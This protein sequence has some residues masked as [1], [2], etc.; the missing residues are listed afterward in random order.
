MLQVIYYMF[1]SIT[2]FYGLYYAITG[3]WGFFKPKT[4]RIKP[5]LPK[6]KFAVIIPARNEAD[7]VGHLVSSL[8]ESNYPKKLFDVYV[9]VNNTTDNSKEVAKKA[10]AKVIDVKIKVK[11]KGE[12]LRYVFDKLKNDK[13]IDAYV[14]FDADNIVHPDFLSRMNDCLCSGYNVAE[15]FRDSK[16]ITDNWISGS[17]SLYYYMQNFFFNKSRMTLG[18]SGSINGTGFMIRKDKIDKEGFE[19]KTMT[20]DIE[21]TAQCALKNEPIA[22]VEGAITYDEQP[23]NFKA[24]WK[25]R[26][27]WSVGC[28]QCMKLY[29]FNLL[30]H[31][32]KTGNSSAFD[33][34]MNFIAPVVQVICLIEF[35]ALIL[36]RIFNVQLYDVFSTLFSSG[37][38]FLA[39]SYISGV[40][41]SIFVIKYNKRKSKN[42]ISAI[43]LFA[44]FILTWIPINV[45]C[46]FK[47]DLKWEE[48]KHKRGMA[49]SDIGIQK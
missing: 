2:L 5:Y 28:L 44:L 22:F 42:V 41:V 8:M 25:Q 36:F 4:F 1:F 10:G 6:H 35:V 31:F 40:I 46:L 33:M 38:V 48:I 18:T 19:T 12:V 11:S 29:S 16:N 43:V 27:R 15:G 23:V 14:I 9:A 26:T 32:L 24:S 13:T 3:L 30:K 20:E 45:L 21:F 37:I 39:L 17:Y 7:V 34:F 49:A 47:K